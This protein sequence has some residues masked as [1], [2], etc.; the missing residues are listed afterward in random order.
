MGFKLYESGILYMKMEE[1]ES[2]EM[3]F[4]RVL[5]Y[6]YDT[7]VVNDAKQGI[8]MALAN[9]RR[10]DDA[11]DYLNNNEDSLKEF[12]LYNDAKNEIDNIQA[13]IE[14]EKN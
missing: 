4:N 11:I 5:E 7:D 13:K 14:K 6:Y 1:Y 3:M 10:I 12:E 9:A 8:V 2:A